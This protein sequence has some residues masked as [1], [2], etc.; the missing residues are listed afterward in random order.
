MIYLTAIRCK[1]GGSVTHL[2]T[3][4]TYNNNNQH[5]LPYS[6]RKSGCGPC[7][8]FERNTLAFALQPRE[9]TE[10]LSQGSSPC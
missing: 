9:S 2:Q 3:E 5:H 7:P 6:G 4:I 1:P 10:N 8:V